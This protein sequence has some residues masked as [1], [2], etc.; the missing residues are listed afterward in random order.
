MG[1]VVSKSVVSVLRRKRAKVLPLT[2]SAGILLFASPSLLSQVKVTGEPVVVP[3]GT[4]AVTASS[5]SNV[6]EP[7]KSIQ[8][9]RV[10]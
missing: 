10:A 7:S 5:L 8:P 3:S 2:I 9:I 6:P 4:K 1:V